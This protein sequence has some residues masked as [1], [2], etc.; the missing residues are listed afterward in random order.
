MDDFRRARWYVVRRAVST[1]PKTYRCPLCG[2]RFPA[3]LEHALVLPEGDTARRRHAHTACVARAHL[4]MRDDV[5]ARPPG[6]L[7]RLLARLRRT[8]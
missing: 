5:E 7:A 4:P 6:M 2:Q 8:P 1:A 3:M